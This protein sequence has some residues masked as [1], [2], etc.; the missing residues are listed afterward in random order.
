METK[1]QSV[2]TKGTCHRWCFLSQLSH[3]DKNPTL[4]ATRLGD[5]ELVHNLLSRGAKDT[6]D[7][8]EASKEIP[9]RR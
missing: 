4:G 8:S 1:V 6:R 3:G 7:L 2:K 9:E 5:F